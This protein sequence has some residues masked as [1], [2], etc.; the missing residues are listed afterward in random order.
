MPTPLHVHAVKG[1]LLVV[2]IIALLALVLALP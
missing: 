1:W 2:G